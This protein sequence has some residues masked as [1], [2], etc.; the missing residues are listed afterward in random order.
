MGTQ[1]VIATL[2]MMISLYA[3]L[4]YYPQDGSAWAKLAVLIAICV[5]GAVVYGVVLLASGFRPRQLRH[6]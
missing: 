5:L 3:V 1:F 6:G 2:A 4:P